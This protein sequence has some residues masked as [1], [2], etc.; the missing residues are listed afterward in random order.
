[1][2]IREAFHS[3]V[4]C[5][6]RRFRLAS[7][8]IEIVRRTGPGIRGFHSMADVLSAYIPGSVFAALTES[9]AID[10][11][12]WINEP[13]TGVALT[14]LLTW[15]CTAVCLARFLSCLNQTVEDKSKHHREKSMSLSR[16]S[17]MV[18]SVALY[19][20]THTTLTQSPVF[21]VQLVGGY[22]FLR[23][24]TVLLIFGCIYTAASAKNGVTEIPT[25][26]PVSVY[27]DLATGQLD[28]C[29]AVFSVQ[30]MLY[31]YVVE[32]VYSREPITHDDEATAKYLAGALFGLVMRTQHGALMT[33][34]GSDFWIPYIWHYSRC[35]PIVSPLG[36]TLRIV[37]SWMVNQFFA[38]MAFIMLPVVLLDSSNSL[39]F[40]KD[41]TCILFIAGL[42]QA[43]LAPIEKPEDIEDI[44]DRPCSGCRFGCCRRRNKNEGH[45]ESTQNRDGGDSI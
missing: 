32:S 21:T 23:S 44:E 4:A 33:V 10:F 30:I 16:A 24:F 25:L 26:R 45:A 12:E 5:P 31:I 1:M 41:A 7:S 40:V 28:E 27:T 22:I 43:E 42:E 6:A 14:L 15:P 3:V 20:V 11:A 13:Q 34:E 18:E 36:L 17:C 29:L 8:D 35:K 19:M 38:E 2:L 9:T 37:M 39:E